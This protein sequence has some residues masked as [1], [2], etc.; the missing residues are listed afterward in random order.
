MSATIGLITVG[1]NH[2][3]EVWFFLRSIYRTAYVHTGVNV[4]TSQQL[5]KIFA[6]AMLFYCC[7]FSWGLEIIISALTCFSIWLSISFCATFSFPSYIYIYILVGPLR[8]LVDASLFLWVITVDVVFDQST[9]IFKKGGGV[10]IKIHRY[11]KL[12]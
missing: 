6:T 1:S 5:N 12:H 9:I 2:W 3:Q 4:D 10:H 11:A 7:N 8:K